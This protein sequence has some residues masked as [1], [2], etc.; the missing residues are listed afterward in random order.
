MEPSSGIKRGPSSPLAEDTQGDRKYNTTTRS[1]RINLDEVDGEPVQICE[2]EPKTTNA[3]TLY[4]GAHPPEIPGEIPEVQV[5]GGVSTIPLENLTTKTPISHDEK[6]DRL[7]DKVDTILG[8]LATNKG[9]LTTINN[10]NEKKFKVLECA[11]NDAVDNI[12]QISTDISAQS[13]QLTR[14]TAAIENTNS[15]ISSLGEQLRIY[16]SANED[17]ISKMNEMNSE[18]KKLRI[19][20]TESKRSVL[21]LGLEVRERRLVLSGVAEHEEEETIST[22]LT[23]VNK[24]LSHALKQTKDKAKTNKSRPKFRLLKMMDIDDAYRM[25]KTNSRRKTGRNLVITFSFTHIRQMVLACKPLLKNFDAKYFL[26]E[27]LTQDAK[28]HRSNLKAIAEGGKKL[29]H[30]TK[31]TGNKLMID[32]ETFQPDE[33]GAVAPNILQAAKYE[34][35]LQD[36]IAFRGDRSIFSNFFPAIMVIEDVEYANVEQFF[37]HEKALACGYDN[38]ARKIMNKVNPWYAKTVGGR[39][40]VNDEWKRIRMRTL[41]NGIYA[42]FDQN[43]PLKQALLN[44]MGLNLY[45]ATSDLLYACGIDLDSPKWATGEWIGENATGKILMKVRGEFLEEDTLGNSASNDTLMKLG[46]AVDST[47]EVDMEG[48]MVEMN[49]IDTG[50]DIPPLEE[51]P[52]EWPTLNPSQSFT[53]AVKGVKPTSEAGETLKLKKSQPQITKKKGRGKSRKGQ[54]SFMKAKLTEEDKEFL[55][56]QSG[57]TPNIVPDKTPEKNQNNR[58]NQNGGRRRKSKTTSTPNR[59]ASDWPNSSNLSPKQRAA[60]EYLGLPPDSVYVKKIISSQ[61]KH[62]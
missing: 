30:E 61:V 9:E 18:L 12:N 33:L 7:A 60:I 51:E 36:G 52:A 43:I 53:D 22:A 8:Y 55:Q 59:S 21:D 38:Q 37:Q 35:V 50:S 10:R 57:N 48:S 28:I 41:Y 17:C 13:V 2:S 14:N 45:E 29:G 3:S 34:R 15:E 58:G 1:K 11:C 31:I 20:L 23:A 32:S 54:T 44:T 6:L 49:N 27:D 16:K 24:I 26:N 25:G 4:E 39:C 19:E 42:K 56:G 40:E 5:P 46:G 47:S 62:K